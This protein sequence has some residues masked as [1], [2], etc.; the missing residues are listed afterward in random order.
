MIK[1]VGGDAHLTIDEQNLECLN[2][3]VDGSLQVVVSKVLHEAVL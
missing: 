1:T 2:A 3:S